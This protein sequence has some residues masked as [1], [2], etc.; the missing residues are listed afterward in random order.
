MKRSKKEIQHAIDLLIQR[1]DEISLVQADV[2]R[3]S[4]SSVQVFQKYV[5]DLDKTEYRDDVYSGASDA[6]KYANM[7]IELDDLIPGAA[8]MEII[9]LCETS[10]ESTAKDELLNVI[11][12][13]LEAVE[14]ELRN[15]RKTKSLPDDAMLMPETMSYIGCSHQQ[16]VLWRRNGILTPHR[17]GGKIYYRKAEIK[18]SKLIRTF[19]RTKHEQ[20]QR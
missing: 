12:K 20:E 7:A 6:V 2:L 18:A 4:L 3:K 8:E 13:R 5:I 19:M 15:L 16:L 11:L 14:K 10:T 17:H 1:G 9:D